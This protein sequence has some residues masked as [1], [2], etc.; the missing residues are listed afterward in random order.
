MKDYVFFWRKGSCFSQWHPSKYEL[1]G[2]EYTTAEQGMMH[3]KALLFED[4]ETAAQILATNDPRKIKQLGRLVRGFKDIV[5]KKNREMIV[6]HN[7]M[8]KFTQNEIMKDVLM[9]TR[10]ALLVEASPSDRIWGIGLREADAKRTSPNKW[11]GLNLLGK[12]LTKVR[13]DIAAMEA[14]DEDDVETAAT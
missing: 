10:G 13:E 6:Y 3:G 12:I 2:Y 9:A 8:A 11:K 7:N 14:L 1:N 5:W 4:N